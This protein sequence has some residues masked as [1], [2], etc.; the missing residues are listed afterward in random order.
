MTLSAIG[1][2][3]AIA[4]AALAFCAPALGSPG[5][6]LY[7]QYDNAAT[8]ASSSQNFETA[9]DP[10]TTRSRT[11]SSF[12][13]ESAGASAGSRC[14]AM[15]FNGAGP[16]DSVNVSIYDNAGDLPGTLLASRPNLAFTGGSS[17]V[18]TV[19]PTIELGPGRHWL[20][21][22]A[23]QS[24]DPSGQWGWLDRTQQAG[25]R[26]CVG[27]PGRS[28]WLRL[29]D[30]GSEGIVHRRRGVSRS[31]LSPDGHGR[32]ASAPP[33]STASASASASATS[34]STAS[35]ASASASTPATASATA[36]PLPRAPGDRDDAHA[37]EGEN[38]LEALLG[39]QGA[40]SG[41]QAI[42][43]RT[44]I[45]QSPRPGA[46]RRRGFPVSL[47]VGRR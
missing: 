7:D 25:R 16:A 6:V 22:Q 11:T 32:T 10:W 19:S 30:L 36:G 43:A 2:L 17:F 34:A 1:K 9:L 27:E 29:H 14:R 15:Y 4:I 40:Q 20:S 3:G 28:A 47:K 46:L 18:V 24:F 45:G 39:R 33:A 13:T 38:P 23:N 31:G 35:A 37:R 44:V 26:R 8:T 12:R 41:L 42:A 21:V 5:D